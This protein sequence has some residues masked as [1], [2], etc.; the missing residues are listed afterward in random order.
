MRSIIAVLIF[1]LPLIAFG[2]PVGFQG[3]FSLI[4]EN[5]PMRNQQIFHYS[6]H[7]RFSLGVRHLRFEQNSIDINAGLAQAAV[8][9]KRWNTNK[10]QA[11]IYAYGGIGGAV[12]NSESGLTY[13]SGVQADAEDR[14][15]YSYFRFTNFLSSKF[16]NLFAYRARVGIAPYLADYDEINSWVM[17]QYDFQPGQSAE[18]RLSPFVRLF[19]RNFLLELGSS[20]RGEWMLNFITEI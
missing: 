10:F 17:L 4:S 7:H 20:T 19:Y 11:N 14:R 13:M 6:P 3:A 5:R 16:E 9:V 15:L 2:R 8:I 1:I 12:Y 18:H